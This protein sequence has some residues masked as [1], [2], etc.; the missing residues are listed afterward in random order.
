M[1]VLL[2]VYVE[3]KKQNEGLVKTFNKNRL[4]SVWLFHLE[5]NVFT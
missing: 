2:L 3:N 4:V 1:T 5:Q